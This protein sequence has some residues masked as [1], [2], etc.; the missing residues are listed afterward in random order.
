M[1]SALTHFDVLVIGGGTGLRIATACAAAGMATAL[2]ERDLF[3]GTDS[4][5]GAAVRATLIDA[6]ERAESAHRKKSGD[7]GLPPQAAHHVLNHAFGKGLS[8][9]RRLEASIDRRIH[10]VL[11]R[12][13]FVAANRVVV[14]GT[15]L[16]A[17]KIVVAA[18]SSAVRPGGIWTNLPFSTPDDVENFDEAPK[19]ITIL[20]GGPTACFWTHFFDRLGS[21]VVQIHRG[22]RLLKRHDRDLSDSFTRSFGRRHRVM[23]DASIGAVSHD[24]KRF[25]IVVQKDGETVSRSS[26]KVV[27]AFG[28]RPSTDELIL[29]RAGV[30]RG[31]GGEIIVDEFSRTNVPGVFAFGDVTSARGSAA[32][33]TNDADRLAQFLIDPKTTAMRRPE[34]SAF[35]LPVRP[36]IASVGTASTG[37]MD[38]TPANLSAVLPWPDADDP[39]TDAPIFKL[40]ADRQGRILGAHAVGRGAADAVALIALAM[41]T[42]ETAADLAKLAAPEKS[43]AEVLVA[44]AREI[45]RQIG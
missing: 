1:T 36:E 14:N 15:E 44:A 3:G 10:I 24:G 39:T 9:A 17:E 27:V 6:I 22:P 28:R 29:D 8:A 33:G 40:V 42:G 32:V 12:A 11:G 19:T 5:R 25:Q 20:G 16:S 30:A 43:R 38:A 34:P 4:R 35:T 26:E 31:Q 13:A 45:L 23:T 2:I 37:E 41:R 18:G 7:A 21:D